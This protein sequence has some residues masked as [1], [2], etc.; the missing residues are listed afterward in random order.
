MGRS[1]IAA[2][3]VVGRI[4]P[5][6]WTAVFAHAALRTDVDS[7]SANERRSLEFS[8]STPS[9]QDDGRTPLAERD[10]TK[11]RTPL[12]PDETLQPVRPDQG[13]PFGSQCG[14]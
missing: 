14:T 7:P 5:S 9:S 4:R 2:P 10:P 11:P 13:G 8:D 3:A 1:E 6:A 12:A